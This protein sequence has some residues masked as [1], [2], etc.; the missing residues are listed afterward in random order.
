MNFLQVTSSHTQG[1]EYY[2]IP[3]SHRWHDLLTGFMMAVNYSQTWEFRAI[4]F[5]INILIYLHF[6][7]IF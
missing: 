6:L 2:E 5:V 7:S 3:A 4:N 1:R